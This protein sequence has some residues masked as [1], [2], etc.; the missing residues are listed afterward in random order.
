M[1]DI[2]IDRERLYDLLKD[3]VDHYS[4]SGREEELTAWLAGYLRAGGLSVKV[5]PVDDNRSN[6]EVTARGAPASILF[7]GH[8]DT[9]PAFDIE[10]YEFS[11]RGGRCYGL[12]TADMK[13]GCAAMIEAF[14]SAAERGSLSDSVMLAL[15]VGEEE[16][17]DGTEALLA[18]RRFESALVG[19]PTGMQPCPSHYGYVEM[20]IR[21][22]GYRRHAAMASRET[23]AIRSLL[24]FLLA[25]EDRIEEEEESILNIRDLHSSESGFAVPDRCA[26][27]VDFHIPPGESAAEYAAGLEEFAR[28]ELDSSG[29]TQ[30]EIEFPT[31]ADGFRLDE[32]EG[33]CASVKEL[34][35]RN[36]KEWRPGEFRS[37]SDASLLI[38]TGC[39]PLMLGPGELSLAHTIDESIDF[40]EVVRAARLYTEILSIQYENAISVELP[41]PHSP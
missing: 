20:L 17:G 12:G 32:D 4:P 10:Q 25:L 38:D 1:S 41:I 14:L 37:H 2:R 24:R 9:V 22:F 6:L 28:Q 26:A 13:G 34:Y 35:R 30:Y 8:I 21:V 7:L 36:K 27:A 40:E 29:A 33:L 5:S 11:E 15:V 18:T 3:M 23:G 31:R 19:E 16:S 39:S